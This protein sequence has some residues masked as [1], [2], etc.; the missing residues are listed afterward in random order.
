M[1]LSDR[2][3]LSSLADGELLPPAEGA[4]AAKTKSSMAHRC[5][6]DLHAHGL[7]RSAASALLFVASGASDLSG[8]QALLFAPLSEAQEPWT[9]K[10]ALPRP[11]AECSNSCA[12][13]GTFYYQYEGY[14]PVPTAGKLLKYS[15]TADTWT[16]GN[17]RPIGSRSSLARFVSALA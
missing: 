16:T 10:K 5:D 14:S 4:A 7:G 11:I 17:A 3:I 2:S 13:Y 6:L 15:T 1:G 8:L 9:S 12:A